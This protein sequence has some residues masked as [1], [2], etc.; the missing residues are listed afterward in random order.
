MV[1]VLLLLLGGALLVYGML[2]L[3]QMEHAVSVAGRGV[4]QARLAA[5]GAVSAIVD[6]PVSPARGWTPIGGMADSVLLV[7][8]RLEAS[9]RMQRIAPELWL[10][11]GLGSV[12]EV[13]QSTARVVWALDAHAR[14]DAFPGVVVTN[15]GGVAGESTSIRAGSDG[16]G[17]GPDPA[18]GC[19]PFDPDSVAV[20]HEHPGIL[21]WWPDSL[22]VFEPLGRFASDPDV[23]SLDSI[24]G[25]GAPA[26]ESAFGACLAARPWNWGDPLRPG[27]PCRSH[28]VT[29]RA[30]DFLRVTGGA[31]QGI[32]VL[33][34]GGVLD[35]T[36][37]FGIVIAGGPLEV[38][39]T[40]TIT[41]LVQAKAGIVIRGDAAIQQSSCWAW[42]ALQDP[43]LA[44]PMAIPGSGWIRMEL[45]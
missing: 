5:R 16:A 18:R 38:S 9:A 22:G 31:G 17:R 30:P 2:A 45:R 13:R 15:V 26:P 34:R 40:T 27:R 23:E 36:S 21:P 1:V 3:S 7:D 10:V 41:G 24:A 25:S 42:A 37:F 8:G 12:G 44:R 29:V 14:V 20:V 28:F 35:D 6:G 39:G 4:A 32:L 43:R 11:R 19:G 33:E